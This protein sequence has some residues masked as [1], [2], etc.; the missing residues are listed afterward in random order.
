MA[1]SWR[2]STLKISFSNKYPRPKALE[3]EQFIRDEVKVPVNDVVGINFSIVSSVVYLKLINDTVCDKILNATRRGLKFRHSDGHIGDVTIEHAGLCTIRVFELPFEV[4]EEEVISALRPYGKVISHVLEKWA[5][6]TT[7]TV[8]NGVRQIRIE[9][10]KHVPSYLTIGGCRAIIIYDG[11]PRTCS[12][13]GQEGHVRSMCMQR[14]ITQ[15]PPGDKQVPSASTTLPLTYVQ[16]LKQPGPTSG[17]DPFL[18]AV[19]PQ[20]NEDRME[21]ALVP[22]S[23]PPTQN[24]SEVSPMEGTE[25]NASVVPPGVLAQDQNTVLQSTTDDK[26]TDQTHSSMLPLAEKPTDNDQSPQQTDPYEKMDVETGVIPT[27][28]FIT[29]GTASASSS[30]DF[31]PRSDVEQHVRKQRSP[32]QHKKRRRTPSDELRKPKEDEDQASDEANAS[33]TRVPGR[34]TARLPSHDTAAT[35]VPIN[36]SDAP[37]STA[38]H[39]HGISAETTPRQLSSVTSASWADDIEDESEHVEGAEG[40]SAPSAASSTALSQ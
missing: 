6:F 37:L 12:G 24:A 16:A 36:V 9:L 5:Q 7:Y 28:A 31:H 25:V 3:I 2:N 15:L 34:I 10:N 26:A 1:Q 32:R 35:T 4:P 39:T 40:G 19:L 21:A 29:T 18:N 30:D 38:E 23:D 17:N 33:A 20:G 11:Q 8:F 13:C 14:R 27:S 22:V